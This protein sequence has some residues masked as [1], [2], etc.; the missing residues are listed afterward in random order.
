MT[1]LDFNLLGVYEV[2]GEDG[3]DYKILTGLKESAPLPPKIED[4]YHIN[5][6][7]STGGR[8]VFF[9]IDHPSLLL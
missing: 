7:S 2:I 5:S 3:P 4:K 8:V 1:N 6:I 9:W